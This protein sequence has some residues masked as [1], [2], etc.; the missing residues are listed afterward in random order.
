MRT[1]ADERRVTKARITR[2]VAASSR[3]VTDIYG[4][5]PIVA[6]TVLGYVGDIHRF[7]TRDHFAAYNG[8]APIEASSS[9]Y[10]VR[11]LSRPPRRAGVECFGRD[12]E[13]RGRAR[14]SI[15]SISRGDC[16]SCSLRLV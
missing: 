8:T 16:V 6:A 10:T 11:R 1:V 2:I 15:G 13:A 5:G 3:S 9:N 4:V 12:M 14:G 7:P